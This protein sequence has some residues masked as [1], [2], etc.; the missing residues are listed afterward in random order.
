MERVQAVA[1]TL[2]A[3]ALLVGPAHAGVTMV[4]PVLKKASDQPH[5]PDRA[6]M[7]DPARFACASHG[8]APGAAGASP[9][10]GSVAPPKDH[11]VGAMGAALTAMPH[12]LA[13]PQRTAP[14][15]PPSHD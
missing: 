9:S 4:Q 3:A 8:R 14:S 10:V 11:H 7:R 2:A 12:G 15:P 13:L 6:C 1:T 5:Q